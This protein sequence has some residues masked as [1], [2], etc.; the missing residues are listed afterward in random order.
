MVIHADLTMVDGWCL[1]LS[2]ESSL[3][4]QVNHHWPYIQW[5]LW[6]IS[7]DG[8][9]AP[10]TRVNS[11]WKKLS[12]GEDEWN[13][14]KMMMLRVELSIY[15]K[16]IWIWAKS[17]GFTILG[18]K[19]KR[20]SLQLCFVFIRG[21]KSRQVKEITTWIT[22]IRD[23]MGTPAFGPSVKSLSTST[24]EPLWFFIIFSQFSKIS[25]R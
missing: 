20:K 14:A 17:C 10:L 15:Q 8:T 23:H 25:P 16:V 7:M 1:I 12:N 21:C 13:H 4:G 3:D 22:I 11:L 18:A 9:S 24:P 6:I 2:I 5:I 19:L